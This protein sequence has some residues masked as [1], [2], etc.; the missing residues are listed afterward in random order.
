[1]SVLSKGIDYIPA[2]SRVKI[3]YILLSARLSI[4]R[5]WKDLKPPSVKEVVETTNIHST[6]E[7]MFAAAQGN[8][9][10]MRSRWNQWAEWYK[11]SSKGYFK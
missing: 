3:T 7:L 11:I 6:F 2:A 5:H 1:M 9:Q 8:Y 10:V 4:M